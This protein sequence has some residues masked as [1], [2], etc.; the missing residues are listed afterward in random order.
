M[1]STRESLKVENNWA[2]MD[3][4]LGQELEDGEPPSTEHKGHVYATDVE[5][6][7]NAGS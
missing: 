1:A 5:Y 4:A 7:T 3:E 2:G 6:Q